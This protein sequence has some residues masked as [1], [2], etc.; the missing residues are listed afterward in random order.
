MFHIAKN[1]LKIFT[2]F[3][4][5]HGFAIGE[6]SQSIYF[7][8]YVRHA[9]PNSKTH[10]GNMSLIGYSRLYQVDNW[11]LEPGI[12]TYIDSYEKRSYTVFTDISYE[13]FSFYYFKPI[14]SLSCMHKGTSHERDEMKFRCAPF[15]KIRMG[16]EKNLFVNIIPVPHVRGVTNG[17][18]AVEV[19]YR[20]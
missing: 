18:I 5:F 19:G 17:F 13:S 8:G 16:G 1:V 3:I 14:L 10:E 4:I 9:K 11:H 20:W 2:I 15:L 7:G 6:E 12:N